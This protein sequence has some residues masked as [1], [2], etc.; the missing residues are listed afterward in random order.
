MLVL[1]D[2]CCARNTVT[3]QQK[4]VSFEVCQRAVS[5]PK[6]IN[7]PEEIFEAAVSSLRTE[8]KVFILTP[9]ITIDGSNDF[10]IKALSHYK[11]CKLSSVRMSNFEHLGKGQK[12]WQ[13]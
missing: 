7:D 6:G 10:T 2:C 1:S 11:C 13:V 12:T 3:L 8:I 4:H 5:L 9:E